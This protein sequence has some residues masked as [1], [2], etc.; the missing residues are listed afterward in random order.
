MPRVIEITVPSDQTNTV[1]AKIKSLPA[2]ISLRVEK[3]ISVQPPG[4]VITVTTAN[5]ALPSLLCALDDIG[6]TQSSATSITT[7]RP[8]SLISQPSAQSIRS[9]TSYSIWEE[10]DQELNKQSSMSLGS[11]IVMAM[12]GAIAIVGILTEALH[13]VIGAMVIAPGFEPLTRFSLGLAN[14]SPSWKSGV[15]DTVKGY[16]TLIAG[17]I[18]SALIMK[19][20]GYGP[21]EGKATYLSEAALLSY[22]TSITA[23]SL[24]ASIAAATAGAFLVLQER[25]VLTAGVMIALALVPS[26][27]VFGLGVSMLDSSLMAAGLLRLVIEIAIVVVMSMVV[28]AWK[29]KWVEKRK[30]AI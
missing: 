4:D 8:L 10:V 13:L 11:M 18:L 15:I 30:M 25:S 12:A 26:A 2:L 17:A 28:L 9:D 22:W 7:S 16:G 21:T 5:A 20:L 6:V 3:N 23:T 27:A 29:F 24:L 1:L 14:R 19:S